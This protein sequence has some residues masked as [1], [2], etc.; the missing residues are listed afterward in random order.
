MASSSQPLHDS[1]AA[2]V[3]RGGTLCLEG[4]E[5][6]SNP[7]LRRFGE[8]LGVA[9]P[10][11]RKAAT[12]RHLL[13]PSECVGFARE[14]AGTSLRTECGYRALEPAADENVLAWSLADGTRQAVVVQHAAGRGRIV[15]SVLPRP[16]AA[17]PADIMESDQAGGLVVPLLLL[18]ELYGRAAWHAPVVLAN[19]S[20]DDPALRGG[21]LGLRYDLLTAQ[22][23][24]HGF[25]VTMATVPRELRLAEEAVVRRL[26]DQPGLLSACYHGCNHDGYEFYL[27][28]GTRTRH[29]PR[30]LEKQRAALWRAVEHGRRF[31]GARKY[32]LDRVMV[33]PYGVGPASLFGDLHRLG[34]LA[35]CNLGDKYP[36]EAPVPAEPDL[37][38][39]PAD[40]AWEGFP[41][42]WRRR[43]RDDGY[44]MDLLLGRPVLLF[45]HA[46]ALGR[47]FAP[48]A[49]RASVINRATHGAAVWRGLDEVARHA[50]LQRS[51]PG[52]GWEVL[53]TANEACLHNP[54]PEPRTCAVTR[55]HLPDETVV[56]VDGV[57]RDL[58]MPLWVTVPP[59]G[60]AVV[61]LVAG[62][63]ASALPG[64]R[65]CTVFAPTTGPIPVSP[66]LEAAR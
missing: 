50:Y 41:L 12:A 43:L 49:E 62:G 23:R 21:M 40:L 30:P 13:F 5:E 52:S 44:L 65:H 31:A 47:D 46:R 25:H 60:T 7:T 8:A 20:I 34:F 27:T 32:Q 36:L 3:D 66:T 38:L 2:F 54:S 26:R 4:L 35:T 33:F 51:D 19:F 56:E 24:D 18:R 28:S 15:L 63:A 55:P 10:H 16:A 37:G 14:L 9:L 22:A 59:R 17:R 58:E 64:R 45:A 53:M 29:S 39:R 1:L 61:R 57:A 11:V 6:Q 42:L 48:L